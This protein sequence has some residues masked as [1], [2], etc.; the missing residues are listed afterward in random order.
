VIVGAVVVGL[1]TVAIACSGDPPAP[2]EAG[3]SVGFISCA[4]DGAHVPSPVAARSDGVHL[5]VTAPDQLDPFLAA[6]PPV[7]L[8]LLPGEFGP[9]VLDTSSGDAVSELGPGVYRIG[10]RDGTTDTMLPVT[11]SLTIIDPGGL[12]VDDRLTCADRSMGSYDSGEGAEG[13]HG[14]LVAAFRRHVTGLL[15]TDHVTPAGYPATKARKVR[16]VRQGTVV[17]VGTYVQPEPGNWLLSVVEKCGSADIGGCPA[18]TCRVGQVVAAARVTAAPLAVSRAAAPSV[19]TSHAQPQWTA[20]QSPDCASSTKP[21][22]S[23][24]DRMRSGRSP[25]RSTPSSTTSGRAM[26][27]SSSPRGSPGRAARATHGREQGVA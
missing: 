25:N 17:A 19:S 8:G 26:T 3:P 7:A 12:W 16:I 10:C 1:I 9:M 15:P 5:V 6:D 20:T 11:A 14:D 22:P 27:S 24:A 23:M 18:P 2:T 21:R 13:E 4:A